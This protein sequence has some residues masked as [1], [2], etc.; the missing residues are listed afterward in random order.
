MKLSDVKKIQANLNN[1]LYLNDVR[2]SLNEVI[3]AISDVLSIEDDVP[4]PSAFC[5]ITWWATKIYFHNGTTL[6]MRPN[7]T[8][9]EA[10]EEGNA[11][12]SY[13]IGVEKFEI[14]ELREVKE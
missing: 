6:V 3:K 8:K 7:R 4:N 12:L 10:T 5:D 14:L 2:L 9:E 11:Y 13:A 1:R